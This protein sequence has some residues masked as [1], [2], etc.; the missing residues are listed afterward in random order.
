VTEPERRTRRRSGRLWSRRGVP[1]E[2]H[3]PV[4]VRDALVA[5][6]AELGLVDPLSLDAVVRH[7]PEMVGPAVAAHARPRSL[8]D[9]TLTIA[10]DAGP[11]ATEVRYLGPE[12]V[13]RLGAVVGPDAVR[14]VRVVVDP[15]VGP[16][17]G[18]DETP[19]AA[20]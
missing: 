15:Q 18:P 1:G 9:A 10:V 20:R 12:L 19:G 14:A 5:V 13:R 3:E 11:W 8:R 17:F 2:E 16:G 7:W 6:S 4:A